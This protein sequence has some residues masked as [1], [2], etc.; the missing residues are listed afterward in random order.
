M[1]RSYQYIQEMEKE[2]DAVEKQIRELEKQE[3]WSD[4]D[5]RLHD[6]LNDHKEWLEKQYWE[7]A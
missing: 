3:E 6:E 2:L 7:N 5:G 1:K 4:A